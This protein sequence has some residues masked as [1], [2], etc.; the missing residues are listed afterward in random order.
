MHYT[1]RRDKRKPEQ[2]RPVKITTG[3]NPYAEGSAEVCFGNTKVL[4]TASVEQ[5]RPKWMDEGQGGWITAEYGM[6]PR[7]THT[8]NRREASSGKQGV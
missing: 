8:R 4:V 3:V 6:L 1:M 2:M 7:S 5:E